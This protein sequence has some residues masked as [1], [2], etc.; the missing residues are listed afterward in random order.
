MEGL[1][2]HAGYD[3]VKRCNGYAG[4]PVS[5]LRMG[6]DY[7][8]LKNLGV[9][10]QINNLLNKEYIDHYVYSAQNLNFLG[11]VSFRF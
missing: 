5:N 1:R 4:N 9:F 11:G 2:V 6:A 7:N 3:Y 10:V 8:L